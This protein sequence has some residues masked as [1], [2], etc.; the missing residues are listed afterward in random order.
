VKIIG[1]DAMDTIV[2]TVFIEHQILLLRGEKV[3]LDRHLAELYDVP[4]MRLNEAVKR[5][6]LRFPPDFMYQLTEE[7]N[8][9]LISQFAISKGRSEMR[10]LLFALIEQGWNN[11]EVPVWRLKI[12]KHPTYK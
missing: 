1:Y 4:M 10:E 7:E 11:L 2:P 9:A 3:M 12:H 6:I 8:E 5:N